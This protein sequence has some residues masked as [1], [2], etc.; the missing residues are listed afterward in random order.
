MK[1]QQRLREGKGQRDMHVVLAGAHI[2]FGFTPDGVVTAGCIVSRQHIQ[3]S[4]SRGGGFTA[5]P[6]AFR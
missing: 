2:G 5:T 1:L 3:D 4:V 6:V